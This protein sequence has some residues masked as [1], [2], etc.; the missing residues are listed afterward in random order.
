[1]CCVFFFKVN[2]E[3]DI[4]L[5]VSSLF[6][7]LISSTRSTICLKI[8]SGIF[9]EIKKNMEKFIDYIRNGL[10]EYNRK[11]GLKLQFIFHLNFYGN[12]VQF[13]FVYIIKW[14]VF[15]SLLFVC[16]FFFSFL[17]YLSITQKGAFL[18][19]IYVTTDYGHT[20]LIYIY[21]C[22]AE[23]YQ[24]CECIRFWNKNYQSQNEY[25]GLF[26]SFLLCWFSKL[27]IFFLNLVVHN[28]YV[29]HAY[30]YIANKQW[31]L[32][33][34]E[35]DVK[36]RW[37]WFWSNGFYWWLYDFSWRG[38]GGYNRWSQHEMINDDYSDTLFW[39]QLPKN[40]A[41]IKYN[42]WRVFR[43]FDSN[44]ILNAWMNDVMNFFLYILVQIFPWIYDVLHPIENNYENHA[45][46]HV[47]SI[48][49]LFSF[50][51]QN[52]STT[53]WT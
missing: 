43:L 24:L 5:H 4:L 21:F 3:I 10:R 45:H 46:L 49:L 8:A 50:L 13:K 53:L 27:Q 47:I 2:T 29:T 30:P 19:V 42:C 11:I 36:G 6:L 41:K 40:C 48:R 23:R 22:F 18:L 12:C 35:F 34:Y 28:P 7:C 25:F 51:I 32:N 33:L 37:N 39:T 44:R 26:R 31:K 16:L 17:S 20:K 1:M 9:G 38:R 14:L 52:Q 15:F